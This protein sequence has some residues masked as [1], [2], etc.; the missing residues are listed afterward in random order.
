MPLTQLSTL[1]LPA[2]FGPMS[3]N[4]S[5]LSTASD[6]PSSTVRP[7]KR[8]VRCSMA[9]SAIPSPAAAV[10]LDV[11][12]APA[13]AAGAAGIEFLDIGMAAQAF[14]GGIEHATAAL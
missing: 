14:G 5:P 11:A 3:A 9:S 13:L 1:V 6:T 2:P 7:P 4:S 12:V 10:L 8:S